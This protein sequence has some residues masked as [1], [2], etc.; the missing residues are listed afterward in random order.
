M[1][2]CPKESFEL[3]GIPMHQDEVCDRDHVLNNLLI[4]DFPFESA[5]LMQQFQLSFWEISAF[6]FPLFRA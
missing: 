5:Q 3:A 2:N 4:W 1:V 6:A